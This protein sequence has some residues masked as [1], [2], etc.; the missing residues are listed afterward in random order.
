[1]SAGDPLQLRLWLSALQTLPNPP[2]SHIFS[3]ALR[4]FCKTRLRCWQDP[5]AKSRWLLLGSPLGLKKLKAAEAD[6]RCRCVELDLEA[7]VQDF[8]GFGE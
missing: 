1:M 2:K 7:E 4:R 3:C 8:S 5:A 6:P